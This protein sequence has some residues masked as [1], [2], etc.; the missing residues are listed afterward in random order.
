MK[1]KPIVIT[2]AMGLLVGC[3]LGITGSVVPSATLRS[4]AWAIDSGGL[5]LAGALLTMYYFR[6]GYDVMAAGFL[7]FAI[8]ESIV[9]S[10]ST[11]NLDDNISSFGAG[12]FLWQYQLQSLVF[13]RHFL[14]LYDVQALSLP[15]YSLLFQLLFLR[16]I[17]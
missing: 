12:I 10:S 11:T 17:R 1:E 5:I 7:I 4:L 13:K 16:V 8:A 6:K 15:F 3:I 14:Y 9:F 2:S